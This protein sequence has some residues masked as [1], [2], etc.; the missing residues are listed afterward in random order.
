VLDTWPDELEQN[1]SGARMILALVK[2]KE[3]WV[4][5]LDD[6]SWRLENPADW[7]RKELEKGL[8]KKVQYVS[9][10]PVPV[11]NSTGF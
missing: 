2:D 4:G 3:K 5:K 8:D 10:S 7:V 11:T 9:C 1:A 6:L